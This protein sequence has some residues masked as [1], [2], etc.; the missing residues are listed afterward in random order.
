MNVLK[1]TYGGLGDG[2]RVIGSGKKITTYTSESESPKTFCYFLVTKSKFTNYYSL[3]RC[4]QNSCLRRN[5]KK[6]E[7]R[8]QK[9]PD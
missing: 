4:S 7:G 5:D 9:Q 1:F 6:K 2:V 8:K 3:L